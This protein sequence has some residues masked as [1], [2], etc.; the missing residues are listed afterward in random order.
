MIFSRKNLPQGFY[1]YAYLREDGTPYY[2]GKGKGERAWTKRKAEINQPTAITKIVILEENLT[3]LGAFAL[4]RRMIRWYGRKDI[5]TGILRNQ[6]EGG[7]GGTVG[8]SGEHHYMFGRKRPN[9]SE[10]IKVNYTTA[11]LGKTG[12]AHPRFGIV[13]PKYKCPHCGI[14]ASKK[15]LVRWHNDR[16]KKLIR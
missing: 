7:A 14:L 8:P 16:C 4:E 12:D 2:I 6:T 9:F 15:M 10:W 5:G 13:D 1:V 3:E 11:L